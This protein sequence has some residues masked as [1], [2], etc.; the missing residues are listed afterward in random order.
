M[1]EDKIPP[2]A[3]A[4]AA[5]FVATLYLGFCLLALDY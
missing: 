1:R 2:S 4:G 3:Y 5:L